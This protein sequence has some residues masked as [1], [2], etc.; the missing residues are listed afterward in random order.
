MSLPLSACISTGSVGDV[1][2]VSRWLSGYPARLPQM[3]TRLNPR[4]GHFRIFASRNRAVRC[5][6][7]AGFLGDLQFPTAL[8]FRRC[9]MLTSNARIGSQDLAVETVSLLA[10]HQSEQGSI[11]C[12]VT[13]GFSQVG[14]VP[15]DAIGGGGPSRIS[16]FPQ[17][18]IPALL[19]SHLI[20][21]PSA[22]KI[23]FLRAAQ[24]SQQNF[25]NYF[26]DFKIVMTSGPHRGEGHPGRLAGVVP[27]GGWLSETALAK[28]HVPGPAVTQCREWQEQQQPLPYILATFYSSLG[29][30]PLGLSCPC[31]LVIPI[32]AAQRKHCTPVQR[33]ARRSEGASGA[34]VN[35]VLIGPALPFLK[36][37]KNIR[38]GGAP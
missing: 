13:P 34:R 9:S 33:L 20:L 29:Q 36:R 24:N 32:D 22:L 11:P 23:S 16:R 7:P 37:S 15:H 2:P 27:L 3:R 19:H 6:L 5:H 21:S 30:S 14:I 4:P 25:M 26:E 10:S 12:R 8:S 31:A 18:C 17:P 28:D 38:V 35:V 1:C